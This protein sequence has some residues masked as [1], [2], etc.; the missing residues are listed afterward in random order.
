[1]RRVADFERIGVGADEPLL[2]VIEADR[3]AID[4]ADRVA[5]LRLPT[6]LLLQPVMFRLPCFVHGN[7]IFA[8]LP[9]QAHNRLSWLHHFHRPLIPASSKNSPP[10]PPPADAPRPPDNS[11]PASP[12]S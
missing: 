3:A 1:M 10:L 2:R 4:H 7:S 8:Q 5:G 9:A 11:A 6:V 12:H